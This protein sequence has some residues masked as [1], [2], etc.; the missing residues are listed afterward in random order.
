MHVALGYY[1]KPTQ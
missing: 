1:T